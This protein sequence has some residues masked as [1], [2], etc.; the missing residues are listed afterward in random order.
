MGKDAEA[1]TTLAVQGNLKKI[2]KITNKMWACA[3]KA[4]MYSRKMPT[5]NG[6]KVVT[7]TK[8][9][10]SGHAVK[11]MVAGSAM[12]CAARHRN[13]LVKYGLKPQKESR[14]Q[15]FMPSISPGARMMLDQWLAAYAQEGMVKA[16][17]ILSAAKVHK[18]MR[19]EVVEMGFQ[20]ANESIFFAAAPVPQRT[21]VISLKKG[22]AKKGPSTKPSEKFGEAGAE[23]DDPTA[24]EEDAQGGEEDDQ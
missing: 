23:E 14:S 12:Q 15:P 18:R 5:K 7:R 11:I 10:V 8:R 16:K 17:T 1:K 20:Q 2:Q 9:L 19:P 4:P 3:H 6:E 24:R 21:V 13:E 22:G